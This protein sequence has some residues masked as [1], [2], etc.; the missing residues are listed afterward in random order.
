MANSKKPRK[1]YKPKSKALP[2]TIRFKNES[3]Y[4][5]QVTAHAALTN[6]KEGSGGQDDWHN[7]AWRVDWGAKLAWIKEQPDEVK[8]D[9]MAAK[10]AV[11]A[12]EARFF[13]S[14]EWGCNEE[15]AAAISTALT[16]TDTMQL[17]LTRRE[18]R[19]AMLQVEQEYKSAGLM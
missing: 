11:E 16:L 7:L 8:S 13:E 4:K 10:S 2:L 1:K 17:L 19:D 3:E 12:I 14:S 6:I 15:E 18:L 9:F 5:L